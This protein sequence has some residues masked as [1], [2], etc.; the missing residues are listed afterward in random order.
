MNK[1]LKKSLAIA[2]A[3]CLLAV[4]FSFMTSAMSINMGT[5]ALRT[6][7]SRGN[8]PMVNDWD[9][10]YSYYSPVENGADNSKKYPLVVIMAGALEGLTEGFELTANSLATW[11]AEEYQSRFTNGGAFLLI[12]RAPEEDELY[13]DSA[14]IMPSFKAAIDDFVS[15]NPNVDTDK[16]Y[17]VGWCLGGTGAINLMTLYPDFFAASIIMCPSRAL[18]MGEASILKDKPVWLMGCKL[19]SYVNYSSVILP[20]WI[21][22]KTKSNRKSDLRFTTS[23]NAPGVSM[24]DLF[25][26]IL[27]HNMWENV[28]Y[29]MHF[30]GYGY[31]KIKSYDGN[32]KKLDDPYAISWLTSFSLE[33]ADT[34][35]EH[36]SRILRFFKE[37]LVDT[38]RSKLLLAV[39]QMI[40]QIGLLKQ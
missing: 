24:A 22:L 1:Y 25:P 33:E 17:I 40:A 38:I 19:D 20:S 10:D 30:T 29:D 4:S 39:I 8:G 7:W 13:W 36:P 35:G 15:K 5:D 28:A 2:L 26:F 31:Y 23:M 9:I 27:N 32:G 6:L 21:N 16:I 14:K 37:D 34:S 11:T 3:T 12:G 18:T